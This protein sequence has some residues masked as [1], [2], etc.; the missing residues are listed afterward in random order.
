MRR[1]Y[2]DICSPPTPSSTPGGGF[3]HY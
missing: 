2:L 1:R 3:I